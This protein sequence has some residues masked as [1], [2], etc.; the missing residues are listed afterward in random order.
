MHDGSR[1]EPTDGQTSGWRQPG[2]V[3]VVAESVVEISLGILR[4]TYL[5]SFV[6][7]DVFWL[8]MPSDVFFHVICGCPILRVTLWALSGPVMDCHGKSRYL[9]SNVWIFSGK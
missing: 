3:E 5:M 1:S 7:V 2:V 8:Q 4:C 6:D 9:P